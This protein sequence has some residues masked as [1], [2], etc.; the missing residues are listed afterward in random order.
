MIVKNAN[1]Y[2][3]EKKVFILRNLL[4]KDGIIAND[5][6]MEEPVEKDHEIIDIKGKYFYPAILDSHCHLV[7]SGKA[8]SCI[9][10]ENINTQK[11]LQKI[12]NS[13]TKSLAVYRG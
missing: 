13:N 7:G 1:V 5:N 12:L 6:L 3:T 10:L 9:T 11:E 4:I 8:V 2:H